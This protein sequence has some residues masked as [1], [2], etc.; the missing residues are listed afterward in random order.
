VVAAYC[1]ERK[2]DVDPIMWWN[3]YAAKGWMIGKSKMVDWRRAV[4]TWERNRGERRPGVCGHAGAWPSRVNTR[5]NPRIDPCV[6]PKAAAFERQRAEAEERRRNAE[7][8]AASILE[9][10]QAILAHQLPTT[11]PS[12]TNH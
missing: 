5:V 12:T 9:R 3:F 10:R 6:D 8:L 1:R 4:I 2:N 11:Q 7:R